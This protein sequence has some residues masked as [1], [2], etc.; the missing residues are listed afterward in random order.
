VAGG[1]GAVTAT[2]DRVAERAN[3]GVDLGLLLTRVFHLGLQGQDLGN[4]I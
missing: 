2:G 1:S 4:E 3:C